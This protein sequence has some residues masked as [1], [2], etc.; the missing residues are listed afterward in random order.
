VIIAPEADSG[1]DFPG[2]DFVHVTPNPRFSRLNGTDERVL[3]LV[4]MFGG[5]LVLGRV[6]AAHMSAD[7]A[8]AQMHP[9]VAHFDAL[10]AHV[11]IRL[12]DL[13]LVQVSAFRQHRFL[14]G[15]NYDFG[16][17]DYSHVTKGHN[18]SQDPRLSRTMFVEVVICVAA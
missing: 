8:Q 1:P 12:F 17:S 11:R 9:G 15:T 10:F 5:V 16:S 6:A 3:C 13:D 14:R 18:H 7:E 4:K 2:L